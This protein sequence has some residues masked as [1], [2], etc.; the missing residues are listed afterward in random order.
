MVIIHTKKLLEELRMRKNSTDQEATKDDTPKVTG[1]G[2]IFTSA[3]CSVNCFIK[4]V[5]FME[6]MSNKRWK[7]VF[8]G[9]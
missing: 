2:G 4:C 6:R 1:I 3:R 5:A 7:K 8:H 9:K